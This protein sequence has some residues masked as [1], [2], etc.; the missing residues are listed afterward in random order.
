MPFALTPVPSTIEAERAMA[1]AF[2]VTPCTLHVS[3][4]EDAMTTVPLLMD[5]RVCARGTDAL[6]K[7]SILE[8]RESRKQRCAQQR[9]PLS[10]GDAG[11]K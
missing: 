7:L 9:F 5:P 6:W 1:T 11:G 4:E 10:L 3:L 2:E 8:A